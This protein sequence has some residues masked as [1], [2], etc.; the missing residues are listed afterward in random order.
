MVTKHECRKYANNRILFCTVPSCCQS[1]I[2]CFT[3]SEESEK[4]IK[5]EPLSAAQQGTEQQQQQQQ[6]SGKDPKVKRSNGVII[7]NNININYHDNRRADS[8]SSQVH[9]NYVSDDTDDEVEKVGGHQFKKKGI[10]TGY[11]QQQQ[12]QQV[13]EGAPP[14]GPRQRGARPLAY[15][16]YSTTS[17][18]TF[19]VNEL[20][21]GDLGPLPRMSSLGKEA[22]ESARVAALKPV[23]KTF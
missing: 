6:P 5:K 15:D 9:P 10:K 16:N 19:S 2:K 3:K 4:L 17:S 12:Q 14:G 23:L 11:R 13:G 21:G 7:N 18:S 22:G 8:R 1:C 20:G